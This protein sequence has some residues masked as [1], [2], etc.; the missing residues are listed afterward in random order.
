M[1]MHLL[2]VFGVFHVQMAFFFKI[3]VLLTYNIKSVSG[4]QCNDS[5]F[6]VITK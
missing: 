1:T 2:R 3:E 5:I 6:V 4:I